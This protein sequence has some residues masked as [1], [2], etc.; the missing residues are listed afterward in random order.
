VNILSDI[1]FFDFCYN[2]HFLSEFGGYVGSSSGGLK[3]YSLLPSRTYVTDR[4]LNS[5]VEYVF[6][7]YLEPRSFT[8]PIFFNDIDETGIRVIAGWLNTSK[9]EKFYFA[10]DSIYC[11]AVLDKNTDFDSITGV[12]GECELSFLANDPYYYSLNKSKYTF[13][14][15]KANS[16]LPMINAG[17]VDCY[18]TITVK[19]SKS[20]ELYVLD[21]N[22]N[23]ISTF[24][25]TDALDPTVINSKYC[26]CISGDKNLYNNTNGEFP[27]FPTGVFYLQ[28]N[29]DVSEIDVEFEPRYI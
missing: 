8:V 4:A 26:T 9:P 11:N 13:T 5:D 19:A 10:D 29:I 15:V 24:S 7:S 3:K 21:I 28:T 2:G 16:T 12:D 14:D 20:F 17:N 23:K 1:N 18:P 6:D 22:Q 25:V 27:V